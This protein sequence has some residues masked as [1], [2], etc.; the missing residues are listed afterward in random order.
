[1]TGPNAIYTP[2]ILDILSREH[3]P[4]TFFVVGEQVVDNPEIL[5][6][7]VR[8]GH[9]VANHT[10]THIDFDHE[11]DFRNREEIIATDHVI[12]ATAGYDTRLFR[13]P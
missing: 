4:A 8:E 1:M 6:R 3:V 10:M 9:M 5:R 2:Q 12:R 13:M 7:I 11:T